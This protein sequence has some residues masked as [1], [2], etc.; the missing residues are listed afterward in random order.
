MAHQCW[1]KWE[2][3]DADEWLKAYTG[4]EW[5]NHAKR[6]WALAKADRKAIKSVAKKAAVKNLTTCGDAA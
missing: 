6:G 3:N 4:Q 1:G 5:S 2:G